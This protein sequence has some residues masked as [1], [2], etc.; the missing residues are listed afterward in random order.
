MILIHEKRFIDLGR[1][2]MWLAEEE[3]F[4]GNKE[5]AT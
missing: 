5:E 1:S 4:I 2:S 3:V